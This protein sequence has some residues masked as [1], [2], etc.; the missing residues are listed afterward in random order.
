MTFSQ[1]LTPPVA[2][3]LMSLGVLPPL[4]IVLLLFDDRHKPGVLWFLVSMCIAGLWALLYAAVTAVQSAALTLALANVFWAMVP[5]AAVAMFLVAYEYVFRE[6]ASRR[7]VAT[8]FVPVLVLFVLSWTNPWNLVFTP[9]YH[10]DDAGL[11][12]VPPLGGP[13]KI[14]VTK[15]YGYLLASLAA[16]MFVGEALR[17]DGLRRRQTLYLLLTFAALAGSTLVKILGLVPEYYDPTSTAFSVSGLVF[18]YSIDRTGLMKFVPVAREQAFQEVDEIIVVVDPRGYVVDVNRFD[19]GFFGPSVLG[20][21]LS[22]ALPEPSADAAESDVP[23]VLLHGPDGPRHF[24]WK[25]SEIAYGRRLNGSLVVLSDITTL[26]KRQE[27]LHLLKQILTRVFR[28]N[29]RNDLNVIEGYA[30]QIPESTAGQRGHIA[31]TIRER[32]AHLQDEAAKA[33]EIER[34]FEDHDPERVTLAD[35]VDRVLV[36]YRD[37]R[38]VAITARVDDVTVAVHPQFPVALSELVENAIVHHQGTGD[39]EITVSTTVSDDRVV[40]TVA[41]DGPGI[42][43]SERDVLQANEETSLHHSSG[44]GLWLVKLVVTRGDGE[45]RI[46]SDDTGTRIELALQRVDGDA[47]EP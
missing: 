37:D 9:A 18:A 5:A 1:L 2:V 15:V 31:S 32:A 17:S 42:P 19:H 12:Q 3:F 43:A 29:M 13:V 34:V 38:D 44:I 20:T 23:T 28:H 8:L 45:L 22:E 35:V 39:P 7:M 10:V 33:Q 11:L 40:L 30:S 47:S 4:A 26:K 21:K 27:D 6:V 36:E 46:D 25:T 24:S 16:G 14:L 41:D